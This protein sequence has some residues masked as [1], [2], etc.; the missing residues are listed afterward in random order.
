MKAADN[1]DVPTSTAR[2][3]SISNAADL[4]EQEIEKVRDFINFSPINALIG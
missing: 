4:T 1:H 2:P 3:T